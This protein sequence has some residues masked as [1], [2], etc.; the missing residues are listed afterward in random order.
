MRTNPPAT[1]SRRP[2]VR[3]LPALTATLIAAV[4]LTTP[5]AGA[6][7]PPP[8]SATGPASTPS[9]IN[10]H[11]P[12]LALTDG[13]TLA[14]PKILDLTAPQLP[15]RQRI[16]TDTPVAPRPGTGTTGP[17]PTPHP[18]TSRQPSA[19]HPTSSASAMDLVPEPTGASASAPAPEQTGASAP[20]RPI[21]ALPQILG[22]GALLLAALTSW[23]AWRRRHR[24]T[25][26]TT[27]TTPAA[28]PARA[29]PAAAA[30]PGGAARLD[31]AL[32][33]LAHRATQHGHPQLPELR[34]ATIGAHSLEV[35][36]DDPASAPLAPFTTKADRWW[37]LP[38]DADLL[39]DD[40]ARTVPAPYPALATIGTT[41]TGALALANLDQLPTLL[42]TGHPTHLT[43]VCTALALELATSP[44]TADT[45]ITTIGFGADLPRLLPA[46]RITHAR[47]PAHALRDLTERLLETHQTLPTERPPHLL[48]CTTALDTDTARQFADLITTAH[49]ARIT[50]IAP[51]H[52][53][54]AHFPTAEILNAS[55]TTPQPFPSL[56]TDITLQRLTHTAYQ[57]ITTALTTPG[58]GAHATEG[59]RPQIPYELQAEPPTAAPGKTPTSPAAGTHP[60]AFRHAAAQESAGDDASPAPHP[61]NTPTSPANGPHRDASAP[62]CAQNS[63]AE[64]EVFPA[65]RNALAVPSATRRPPFTPGHTASDR[66]A[67]GSTAAADSP[68]KHHAAPA[69]TAPQPQTRHTATSGPAPAH[70]P[71]APEIRVLGPLEVDRV[72]TGGH[73]PRIAQ[74]A[75]LLYFRPHHSADTLCTDMDPHAPWS[76][77]T[78]NARLQGLRRALGND[79]TGHPYVPRRH[80]ADDPYQLSP[81]IRCDWTTFQNLTDHALGQGPAGLPHLE[82]ALTLV[83]G[84]P[85]GPRPPAWAQPLQQEMITRIIHVAHTIAHYRT[86]AGPHHNLTKARQAIATGLDVDDTTEPLYRDWIRIEHTAGNR[87]G[88]HTAITRLQ[89][90]NRALDCSL[91]IDDSRSA[92]VLIPEAGGRQHEQRHHPPSEQAAMRRTHRMPP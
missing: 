10:A 23:L 37:L 2:A 50:L 30:E 24:N 70:D 92:G 34:A 11:D 5:H 1:P 21:P 14:Q 28:S 16:E 40:R 58:P 48:L 31:R 45:D 83:R 22:A 69:P 72:H 82:K 46:R 71:N 9:A 53:A 88:L 7:T 51:A 29:Q 44:W 90:A 13:T 33:T 17:S 68:P 59:P 66:A 60:E 27:T 19:A 52:G 80:T 64:G 41:A 25:R 85:F 36:P 86:P 56:G 78:L 84:R 54:A 87:Q 26:S 47:H 35:L 39:D 74:L 8:T 67:A 12:D 15:L 43:E 61:A 63:A 62:A 38:A 42:L 49:D 3:L 91:E 4:A 57:R 6:T 77:T 76:T 65:L 20:A 18:S 55:L 75:A 79:P 32:R 89:H 73:G 81:A